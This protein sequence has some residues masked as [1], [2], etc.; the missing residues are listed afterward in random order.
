MTGDQHTLVAAF[1]P[2]SFAFFERSKSSVSFGR[3]YVP[4]F[5]PL[6]IAAHLSAVGVKF[7]SIEFLQ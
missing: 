1:R 6:E 7:D 5:D 3:A 2:E 4:W